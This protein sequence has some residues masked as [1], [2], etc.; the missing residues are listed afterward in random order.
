MMVPFRGGSSP[1]TRGKRH[2]GA[3]CNHL[4]GLIPAHA[5]KTGHTGYVSNRVGAHP[6]SRGENGRAHRS[7]LA[8]GGSSP[9]TGENADRDGTV[10]SVEGSSPLTRGKRVDQG[11]D[12]SGRGLI[13]AHAGKTDPR[14]SSLQWA[15]AH[16]RSRGENFHAN[17]NALKRAGSS[18]LTRGKRRGGA[19]RVRLAVAHPRSRGENEGGDGF[20][21]PLAGSSP[22]TRG[23]PHEDVEAI[24]ERRLIPAHAGKTAESVAPHGTKQAHPRSRGEN[25]Y[26]SVFRV[27]GLGSSPL[28]RGKLAQGRDR[29][30]D[31]GLIPAHAGKT[32]VWGP[33]RRS[34]LAHPRSRG[35]NTEADEDSRALWGSSPLTRGKPL[36]NRCH[37]DGVGLIP[38]HAGK[39][40]SLSCPFDVVRAHPR[41]RGENCMTTMRTQTPMGSSPLTR[42]KH[43]GELG[44]GRGGGLIPAHAG[45]T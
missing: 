36:S 26:L 40:R 39:T 18:P 42:G 25:G 16:P 23:K 1:L 33:R 5:G 24:P 10:Y 12:G 11:L 34:P 20:G 9:L 19:R 27:T 30:R 21:D 15:R 29:A 31:A 43:G 28:T 38:A 35:E 41:S 13:P 7:T 37:W 45:K 4:R 3:D 22:L 6:R 32:R 44:V 8:G 14:S 17:S 2:H